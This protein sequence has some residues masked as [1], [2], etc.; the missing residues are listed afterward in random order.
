MVPQPDDFA[1]SLGAHRG[2]LT[3]RATVNEKRTNGKPLG[4]GAEPDKAIGASLDATVSHCRCL[5]DTPF[6]QRQTT[7]V[8]VGR[9]C[10]NRGKTHER[11]F[12]RAV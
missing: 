4:I 3:D 10:I 11:F 6:F 8:R 5:F 9:Q 1:F 7:M 2:S 12:L